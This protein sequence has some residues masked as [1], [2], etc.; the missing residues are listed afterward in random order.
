MKTSALA[1]GGII[2]IIG[3]LVYYL[4]NSTMAQ[5][6]GGIVTVQAQQEYSQG[7]YEV[8]GGGVLMMVGLIVALY[9]LVVKGKVRS[10]IKNDAMRVP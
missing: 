3:F 6:S 9:A 8:L 2:I 4:G 7:Q 10:I 5:N 1:V